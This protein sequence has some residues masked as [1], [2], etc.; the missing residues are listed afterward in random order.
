MWVEKRKLWLRMSWVGCPDIKAIGFHG[1]ALDLIAE[2]CQLAGKRL[3]NSGFHSSG[4]FD[5]DELASECENVHL[6]RID[7][8]A[9]LRL[10]SGQ[11]PTQRPDSN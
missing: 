4:G 8:F 2:L 9:I 3:A 7:D 10:G 5:I 6:G 11:A 1:D